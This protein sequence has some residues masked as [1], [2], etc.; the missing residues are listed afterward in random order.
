MTQPGALL[1]V[2]VP[3][4]Q[5]QDRGQGHQDEWG[6]FSDGDQST[7]LAWA[8][9]REA[10]F[11]DTNGAVVGSLK[12]EYEG[13]ARA[14]KDVDYEE[15]GIVGVQR[16]VN[17]SKEARVG[18]FNVDLNLSGES[19]KFLHN[20]S[21]NNWTFAGNYKVESGGSEFQIEYISNWGLDEVDVR[22]NTNHDPVL[23]M[24]MGFV[25]AYWLHP[26]RAEEVA[27]EQALRIL[28]KRA[29]AW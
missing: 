9:T 7:V 24:A 12:V 14:I 19:G 3:A 5:F 10:S 28:Q 18:R 17:W 21:P 8:M 6:W 22:T 16:E 2:E 15:G 13:S 20:L 27:A 11:K 26:K 25:L 29:G 1:T 23:Q 4:L